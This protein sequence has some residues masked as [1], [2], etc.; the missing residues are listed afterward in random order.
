MPSLAQLQEQIFQREGFRVEFVPLNVK[1]R[2]F[3]AYEFEVMASNKWRVSDWRMHRLEAYV[4]LMRSLAV[5]RGDGTA[6][7]TDMRL[8]NLRDSYFDAI[9]GA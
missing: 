3:P 6:V 5:L 1:T 7:K 8:G 2:T 9:Y 4:P